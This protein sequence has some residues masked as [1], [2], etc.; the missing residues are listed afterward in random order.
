MGAVEALESRLAADFGRKHC[1]AVGRGATA[2]WI[3][4]EAL[5][6]EG[7][8]VVLPATLCTSPAAVTGLAGFEPVFCDVDPL[9]GNMSPEALKRVLADHDDIACVIAAHLYG[10]PCEI[11]E[12][13]AACKR[14]G[15]RLMEDAAQALGANIGGKPVGAFGDLSILS[16]GHTKILDAGIGGA[17]L[18]DD[19]RLAHRLREL[20]DALPEPPEALSQWSADYRTRYYSLTPDIKTGI[21]PAYLIGEI[22]LN[23]PGLYRYALGEEGAERVFEALDGL[24][25]EI[26]HRRAMAA[27]YR[28]ELAGAPVTLMTEQPGGV[29]WRFNILIEA[30]RRDAVAEALRAVGYDASPWYPALPPFFGDTGAYPNAERIGAEICNLWVSGERVNESYVRG[31]CATIRDCLGKG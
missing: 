26:A 16:F 22:C 28:D 3:G 4:L 13:S 6:D 30:D 10:Q 20:A 29:P 11:G 1:V 15:A 5:K 2:I 14:A 7:R 23:H 17:V 8:K 21:Q 31:V 24:E 9:S 27:L 12:I 19:D 18:T 25:P